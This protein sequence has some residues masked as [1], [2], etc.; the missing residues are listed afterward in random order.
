MTLGSVAVG[1]RAGELAQCFLITLVRNLCEI[2]GKFQAHAFTGAF[3]PFRLA[4]LEEITHR[5]VEDAR[6]LVEPAS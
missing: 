1:E 4:V 2:A 6:D 5:E 3:G